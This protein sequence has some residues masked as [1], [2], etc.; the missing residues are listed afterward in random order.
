MDAEDFAVLHGLY[1]G[2]I[3]Y[4]D[5]RVGQLHAALRDQGLLDN[6]LFIITSDHGENIGEHG[7]MDH[8][9]CLYDTLLRVP[10]IVS[11]LAEFAPGERVAE[12]V[13]T[14]DL[15]PTILKVAGIEEEETW[16]QVQTPPLFPRDVR[17]QPERPAI[18]EYLEPQPPVGIL[19]KRYPEFDASRF[20]RTLRTV[21][22]D[23]YKYIWASDGRDELYE[24]AS[25]PGEERNLIDAEPDVAARLRKS[26]EEW[27]ASFSPARGG[28]EELEL[29]AA[30]RQRLE[31]LGYLA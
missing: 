27:L 20:D 2:E 29:D 25:D 5:H 10:L 1:D 24:I 23:G 13:Q 14:P 3:S 18:A 7:L 4:V 8:V 12:Q 28:D 16:R 11:G 17:G 6:T 15:F 26:L 19:R 9:Y 22:A 21:R 30:M 31:D